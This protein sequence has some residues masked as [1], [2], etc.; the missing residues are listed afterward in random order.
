MLVDGH[1]LTHCSTCQ[2]VIS[3]VLTGTNVSNHLNR[4][5]VL[6]LSLP[7]GYASCF[8]FFFHV[9]LELSH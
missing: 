5:V 8:V 4:V 6:A 9:I 3:A 7:G 2:L 1:V